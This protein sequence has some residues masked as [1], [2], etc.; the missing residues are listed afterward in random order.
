M[1]L[2]RSIANQAQ[3]WCGATIGIGLAALMLA[4]ATARAF[5]E[6]N[7]DRSPASFRLISGF[8]TLTVKG[9]LR[10][11]LHDLEGKGGPGY[12]SVT[13]TRTI[14]TRSPFVDIDSFY[15]TGRLKL[16]PSIAVNTTLAFDST[17]AHAGDAWFDL[18][19]DTPGLLSH[20]VEVGRHTPFVAIDRRT[21]RYPLAGTIYWRE[22]EMHV[23]YEVATSGD[24][25]LGISGGLS[26]ALV[27]PLGFAGVQ[28]SERQRGTINVLTYDAESVYS[29]I[30]AI[31]GGKLALRAFG[32]TLEGFGFAGRL[33]AE[34]GTDELS[35][36][37]D[38]FQDLPG[39]DADDPQKL[40][41]RL[42][43]GGGRASFARYSILAVAEAI[44][45]KESLIARHTYYGQLSYRF[46]RA[47]DAD[48][49]RSVE[50]LVRV[51]QYRI[52]GSTRVQASGRA[53]RSPSLS[54]AITWDLDI[55]TAALITELYREILQCRLEYYWIK[56]HNGVR[57]L[58]VANSP[59]RNNELLIEV[60]VR[61]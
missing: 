27:R 42:L 47:P 38:N 45:S 48:I 21:A 53:L 34:E 57:A 51:E 30:G 14:G 40:N 31:Y 2:R 37:L 6:F 35:S 50:P 19:F 16:S 1:S 46:V 52:S 12:D 4:P 15:L 61:F 9:D 13:D 20:H 26:A 58:A 36:N 28:V 43:W 56:E 10:I 54:Q 41:R 18:T 23:T 39:F 24:P 3:V 22:P 33:A 8:Q 17:S 44:A 59:F 29:G 55:T 25:D 7:D 49:L 32:A 11:G 5:D 60:A